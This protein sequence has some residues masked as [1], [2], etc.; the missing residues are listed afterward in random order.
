MTPKDFVNKYH[1][2]AILAEKE[3]GI[4][5]LAILAQSAL[6][7]G[8]GDHA[9]NNMM[10]GIKDTDGVNGN[11]QLVRTFEYHKR[12]NLTPRQAGLI[13]IDKVTQVDIKGVVWFKYSGVDYFRKYPTPKESFLDHGKFF[14]ENGRYHKALTV[15]NEPY[16]FVEEIAKA[17]YATAPNYADLLKSII[18]TI[19]KHVP[20]K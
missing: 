19:Q 1:S 15:A 2:Y 20:N 7:T 14:Y 5:A 18:K 11:E 12:A 4:S 9:P 13:R 8:W 17:G 3:N 6:E 10:F 16:K